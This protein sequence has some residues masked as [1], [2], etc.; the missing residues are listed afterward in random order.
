MPRAVILTAL[1]VEYLA[2]R[3]HL[4]E[5]QEKTHPQGT[6]YEQGKFIG[7]EQEWEV[8]I[9]EVGAGNAGAAVEAERAIAYFQPNI[10]LF[11]G[12]A[13]GIKDVAIG[14]VVVATDVYGY[15][16][17][18]VGEQFFPRPKVGKSAYAL[19][20][21]AKSEAKKEE[22]LQR[23][24]S[25][26][27]PQ[28]RVFVAPIA[29]GE[30]IIADRHSDIFQFLRASYND[31]IAVEMEGFGFLNAAFAYPD[32]KAV[33]IRGISDLIEG[34]NDDSV[35]SEE[36]RQ[37]K[38]SHHASAFAFEML[39]KLLTSNSQFQH[40]SSLQS[41]QNTITKQPYVLV[42]EELLD[43][44]LH[45]LIEQNYELELPGLSERQ[46]H[47]VELETV[48]VALRGDLSNPYERTQGRVILEQRARQIN[49]LLA[50]EELTPE[51]EF[52]IILSLVASAPIP[53]SIEERDRPHLFHKPNEQTITLGEA[54]QQE[55]RLVILGDPGSGK[56]TLCHWL[57]LKLAQAYLSK[58]EEV[59][60]PIHHV[61]PAADE[62]DKVVSLGAT[63]I[64]ILVR[65]ASFANARKAKPQLRLAQFLGHHL[66]SDADILGRELD[67]H[68][69]NELFLNLLQSGRV[70]LLLDGLDEI[71]DQAIRKDIVQEIDRFI[72]ELIPDHVSSP[73][74]YGGNQIIITSRIVGYQMASLSNQSTHLTIEPMSE[75]AI[76]R[77]CDVWM[78]A[79]HKASMPLERWNAEA[80]TAAIQEATELKEAI[81]D[82]QQR[83]AGDLASNPLLVA[84]L[85]LVFRNGERQQGKASFPQ[86]RVKL[87]EVAVSILIN[88]WRE[89]AIRNRKRAFTQEE[90]LKILVPL[91]YQIHE[92]SDIGLIDDKEL[93]KFLQQHLSDLDIAKFQN[94]IREEVG[95]LAA[96]G[97]GVYGFLHLTFQ[98]YLAAQYLI[99]EKDKI[100]ER[101]LE[102][103]NS[104]RWRE[105][106]LMALGN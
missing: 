31:A 40:D 51:Q 13:G 76:N 97:E 95:L 8:G 24:S 75:R 90:V 62:T 69:L 17:G 65:V 55:S 102:K 28:P 58:E 82:L 38:A 7:N 10:L 98:E 27:V 32:I 42:E 19:V 50:D 89:P 44:Y 87:Y 70:I 1:P 59:W 29:A 14:D 22:W 11:V 33:V 74:E 85:A 64:P 68:M 43:R 72:K 57:A 81:A 46:Y 103:L 48:Y 16:S 73:Y 63:R 67:S 96:R 5:L 99:Q 79:I 104:P 15:E 86:Q 9:A 23:L 25:N 91:A 60:V 105:P 47:P 3:T 83:G 53:L 77:F 52:K 39:V 88:R 21:R 30:K 106:I 2:V 26:P 37:E 66:G 61:N 71:G 41:L 49:N 35:E 4:R 18:K 20:Q 54:V 56:T 94:V 93:E 6:I 84:I 12:I 34:K 101:L 100:G 45:W 92:T 78:K 80:E 36:V